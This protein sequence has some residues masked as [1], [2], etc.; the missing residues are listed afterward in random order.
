MAEAS[1]I[2]ERTAAIAAEYTHLEG[3]L[4]PILHAVQHSF[5]YVPEE[6]VQVIANAINIARAEVHGTLTFYPDFRRE[7]AGKHVLKLCRAEACQ[8]LGADQIAADIKT[9][10][11]I[12]FHETTAD[13]A[14][15]LEP[16]FC[17][18]LCSCAP[19]AILDESR[20]IGRIDA[21]TVAAL[22]AEVTA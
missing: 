9:N 15:T 14:L 11:G 19:A 3:P 8:S 5:G 17:L 16:I 1:E 2:K 18:G 12:D 10:L 21:D 7:P 4:M 6:S 20:V 13:G 22:V